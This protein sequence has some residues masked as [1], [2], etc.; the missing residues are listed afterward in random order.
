MLLHGRRLLGALSLVALVGCGGS[1]GA[2]H[3]SGAPQFQVRST[4]PS[5]DFLNSSGGI[6][7]NGAYCIVST[8]I[9]EDGT[10]VG[11]TAYV[12]GSP[13]TLALPPAGTQA[14]LIFPGGTQGTYSWTLYGTGGQSGGTMVWNLADPKAVPVQ[15]PGFQVSAVRPDGQMAVGFDVKT[16]KV[17]YCNASGQTSA[18]ALPSGLTSFDPSSMNMK[19]QVAGVGV[20][21]T[22]PASVKLS[23]KRS[24]KAAPL[25]GTT[26]PVYTACYVCTSGGAAVLL[27]GTGQQGNTS[28]FVS[29]INSRG[30]CVGSNPSLAAAAAMYW[31]AGGQA[32][33][34]KQL[35]PTIVPSPL[36]ISDNNEI[37]GNDTQTYPSSNPA[38]IWPSPTQAPVPIASV[39]TG[40]QAGAYTGVG[41]VS[42]NGRYLVVGN[43]TGIYVLEGSS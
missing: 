33:V 27:Q 15:I 2:T 41:P 31:N 14:D 24:A 30:E 25:T 32:T 39:T 34:L 26:T 20:S 7:N 11:A 28:F 10:L 42:S 37:F 3:G 5:S 6:G 16:A 43:G 38:L 8:E 12:N 23:T 18:F 29:A 13:E 36:F 17:E 9:L 1:G 21:S 35:S 19:N 40:D 22:A 4:I